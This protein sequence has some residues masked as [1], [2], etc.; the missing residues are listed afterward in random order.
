MERSAGP[1]RGVTV[2]DFSSFLAGPFCTLIL[3][4]LGARVIKVEAPVG[5]S[6]RAVPPHFVAGESVYYLGV[7]RN[8]ESIVI[9]LK[10]EAGRRVAT[11]LISRVD[12]VV[13]NFRPGVGKELGL[14]S[15]E[16]C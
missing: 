8:K 7:N 5:D 1:L 13:E 15:D 3:A 12:V 16:L 4:D 2:L 14:D 6:S 9:N 10:S 11:D